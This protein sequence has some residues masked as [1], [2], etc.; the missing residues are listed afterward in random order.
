[1]PRSSIR[2]FAAASAVAI[3]ALALTGCT[4][5]PASSQD[6][7]A[8]IIS[9]VL[10]TDDSA[11]TVTPFVATDIPKIFALPSTPAPTC[12]YVTTSTPAPTNGVTYVQTQRTLL[13]IGISDSQSAAMIAAIRKTVSVAPWTVRFDYGATAPAAGATPTASPAS[14]SSSTRT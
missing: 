5:T 10:T 6:D 11:T 4:Q 2:A 7:C 3:A 12:Y 1:M 8:G 13:Y 9:K 14:T